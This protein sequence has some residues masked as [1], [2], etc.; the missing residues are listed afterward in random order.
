VVT[1]KILTKDE[2]LLKFLGNK[3]KIES[4][5]CN[6]YFL[7][8]EG[9]PLNQIFTPKSIIFVKNDIRSF[10][11]SSRYGFGPFMRSLFILAAKSKFDSLKGV[12][13][14]NQYGRLFRSELIRISHTIPS[15]QIKNI[16]KILYSKWYSEYKTM[17]EL[18]QAL[19]DFFLTESHVKKRD[20]KPEE[21]FPVT[22]PEEFKYLFPF[23]GG[24]RDDHERL[25]YLNIPP[26]HISFYVTEQH[27][28][29][30][31]TKLLPLINSYFENNLHRSEDATFLSEMLTTKRGFVKLDLAKLTEITKDGKWINTAREFVFPGGWEKVSKIKSQIKEEKYIFD[32][33]IIKSIDIIEKHKSITGRK[34][35]K[36]EVIEFIKN[37]NNGVLLFIGE[38]G[39]GKT[40]LLAN[41]VHELKPLSFKN[42]VI[43]FF[44]EKSS[45]RC[46]PE[47]C[48]RS[49]YFSLAK[50]YAKKV[51][52]LPSGI[53]SAA[54]GFYSLLEEFRLDICSLITNEIKGDL[55]EN[56]DFDKKETNNAK[57]I[58]IID[59]IDEAENPS[60]IIRLLSKDLPPGAFFILSSR[61]IPHLDE[62]DT[63]QQTHRKIDIDQLKDENYK[64]TLKYLKEEI[65]GW[66]EVA[67][68]ELANLSK[69]NFLFLKL[70]SDLIKNIATPK[71]DIIKLAREFGCGEKDQLT[72]YYKRYWRYLKEETRGEPI[73]TL[74]KINELV[75]LL[76]ISY[77]ALTRNQILK[78]LGNDWDVAV[79]EH[80]LEYIQQF[81]NLTYD[82][83]NNVTYNLFHDTFNAFIRRQLAPDLPKL[84]SRIVKTYIPEDSSGLD[85][86]AIDQYGLN[87]LVKH[88]SLSNSPQI[89]IE[90][91]SPSYVKQKFF[92]QHTISSLLDDLSDVVRATIDNKDLISGFKFSLLKE[93]L[94][95][96]KQKIYLGPESLLRTRMGERK[97]TISEIEYFGDSDDIIMVKTEL[98]LKIWN[99]NPEYEKKLIQEI[100]TLSYK[101]SPSI[102]EAIAIRAANTHPFFALELAKRIPEPKLLKDL[103]IQLENPTKSRCLFQISKK[104]LKE[105]LKEAIK[106]AEKVDELSDKIFMYFGIASSILINDPDLSFKLI[107]KALSNIKSE[108]MRE[109]C[110]AALVE[111]TIWHLPD[112]DL[113]KSIIILRHLFELE[114]NV[115][116]FLLCVIHP[117]II[118][119]KIN[120]SPELCLE[121]LLTLPDSSTK[122]FLKWRLMELGHMPYEKPLEFKNFTICDTVKA[123][124]IAQIGYSEPIEAVKLIDSMDTELGYCKAITNI[125]NLI[126]EDNPQIAQDI[127][128]Y[129]C[130]SRFSEPEIPKF[131]A[132]LEILKV[133]ITIPGEARLE[134]LRYCLNMTNEFKS[135]LIREEAFYRFGKVLANSL[136]E[137][138][139]NEYTFFK[140]LI[141]ELYSESERRKIASSILK[142]LPVEY[143][144]KVANNRKNWGLLLEGDEKE[145]TEN[146]FFLPET[147]VYLLLCLVEKLYLFDPQ[148]SKQILLETADI[149]S[150]LQDEEDKDNLVS[151][152]LYWAMKISPI[153]VWDIVDRCKANQYT[154]VKTT[155]QVLSEFIENRNVVKE[156]FLRWKVE[157]ILTRGDYKNDISLREEMGKY[158]IG[159][160]G[161]PFH[162]LFDIHSPID[163]PE[164]KW[165][166]ELTTFFTRL[167]ELL[168]ERTLFQSDIEEFLKLLAYLDWNTFIKII[169]EPQ[170]KEEITKISLS[171]TISPIIINS[172]I[173]PSKLL[174]DIIEIQNIT[175]EK[176][177]K[178]GIEDSSFYHAIIAASIA[179]DPELCI[180]TLTNISDKSNLEF[181]EYL[182]DYKP[183]QQWTKQQLVE[184]FELL[185][186]NRNKE[187][188]VIAK[189][190]I[191]SWY[192]QQDS[193]NAELIEKILHDLSSISQVSAILEIAK[194]F[195]QINES[196]SDELF[197]KAL[198]LA[199]EQKNVRDILDI[200]DNWKSINIEKSISSLRIARDN[201]IKNQDQWYLSKIA[202]SQA[203]YNIEESLI[204]LENMSPDGD[205]IQKV[206][207]ELVKE[208]KINNEN[209]VEFWIS[210]IF[211]LK[212]L[213]QEHKN[214]FSKA[215][216]K[217]AVEKD[218]VKTSESF[219][220]IFNTNDKVELFIALAN[221]LNEKEKEDILTQALKE[222][223]DTD[224]TSQKEIAYRIIG[225]YY[226]NI[227]KD[228]AFEFY[229]LSLKEIKK[230][231]STFKFILSIVK[232]VKSC[233]LLHKK[234]AIEL[235][236]MIYDSVMGFSYKDES[237]MFNEKS[238]ALFFSAS[239]F[240]LID[241]A[242]SKRILR[243]VIMDYI[244]R[245]NFKT[246]TSPLH[247]HIYEMC[248]FLSDICKIDAGI[249]LLHEILKNLSPIQQQKLS[250]EIV[251]KL[252]DPYPDREKPLK[253]LGIWQ[254][255]LNQNEI[256]FLKDLFQYCSP[257]YALTAHLAI[258]ISNWN[259]EPLTARQ[260][261]DKAMEIMEQSVEAIDDYDYEDLSTVYAVIN[262]FEGSIRA[263]KAL[264]LRP[265]CLQKC[266]RYLLKC[267]INQTQNKKVFLNDLW[268]A[269]ESLRKYQQIGS[270]SH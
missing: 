86:N 217:I 263:L 31:K 1:G 75:G 218:F 179:F 46:S 210:K 224:T 113:K 9:E 96:Q 240:W 163:A 84:H 143:C 139:P 124:W 22:N 49:L 88:A 247:Y 117:D 73:D 226:Q 65:K 208:I 201:A 100:D 213:K 48:F 161:I 192:Y 69:G 40:A 225:D 141:Q 159:I 182:D 194:H 243:E 10:P 39:I 269:L 66:K 83:S 176:N 236:K 54:E 36:N 211:T 29:P 250:D 160:D 255:I 111:C 125:V 153:F 270:L 241:K 68:K 209:E 158:I 199:N 122:E 150:S 196:L 120:N 72:F 203:R 145:N 198:D 12:I 32:K 204:T 90:I 214:E 188:A 261:I 99:T 77:T 128:R 6:K 257:Q 239:A 265:K 155:R 191:L 55:E 246:V 237:I 21:I 197:Q 266:A 152:I 24:T 82:D 248:L 154:L 16:R 56:P 137:A 135:A 157:F 230:F 268:R 17:K 133:A 118:D 205:D 233:L 183:E 61:H 104:L 173:S 228:K 172:P 127:M 249:E 102:L 242:E 57:E 256:T 200:I 165:L 170:L 38:P 119:D 146:R 98:L 103:S 134:T 14:R 43:S 58:I 78:F 174:N 267:I 3:Q 79:F 23:I 175:N 7:E 76:A 2:V 60:L 262:G 47:I 187:K 219:K 258:A 26:D 220:H 107:K 95:S 223:K 25:W 171:K 167:I 131:Y 169:Q 53:N 110:S 251:S 232:L 189:A 181:I 126:K 147:E 138:Y 13:P 190:K 5:S 164:E 20:L 144:Q 136:I 74:K 149:V 168:K 216:L 45:A 116:S 252:C 64:D 260:E 97:E 244:N 229:K 114:S 85:L 142:C 195:M 87:Y 186:L 59:A 18:K 234:Q 106:I 42:E 202:I 93:Q 221:K 70:I 67:L 259:E 92:V 35:I 51:K 231:D 50:K 89:A 212:N 254:E 148:I 108:K 109:E 41:L 193:P 162:S 177:S 81:I 156:Q 15:F 178:K 28:K 33:E 264:S 151:E 129:S 11:I 8:I 37:N 19:E 132:I 105:N 227:D 185:A 180:S 27:I 91:M 130:I 101:C 166:Q 207:Q 52:P 140:T 123:Y 94:L 222:I 215:L 115:V 245:I 184:L 71:T 112:I 253:H 121:S 62:F 63:F 4:Y 30:E 206:L 238:E 34:I 44:F 235:A 80:I